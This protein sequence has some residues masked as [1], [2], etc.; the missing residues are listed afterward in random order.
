MLASSSKRKQLAPTVEVSG[1]G[2]FT[3]LEVLG[4]AL[5][6]DHQ[7]RIAFDLNRFV[8][9]PGHECQL[10]VLRLQRGKAVGCIFEGDRKGRL[11]TGPSGW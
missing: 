11:G 5:E 2:L 8:L 3:W 1:R 4:Q 9:N 10:L 6:P 7:G